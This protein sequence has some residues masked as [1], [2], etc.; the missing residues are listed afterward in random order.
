VSEESSSLPRTTLQRILQEGKALSPDLAVQIITDLAFTLAEYHRKGRK[1]GEIFPDQVIIDLEKGSDILSLTARRDLEDLT[2]QYLCFVPPELLEKETPTF[3]SDIYSLGVILYALL[4]GR[5]PFAAEDREVL[6]QDILNSKFE[7]LPRLGGSWDQLDWIFQKCVLRVA[8]RRFL[9]AGEFAEELLKL[10]EPRQ[11]VAASPIF[12]ARR[13]RRRAA[14]YKNVLLEKWKYVLPGGLLFLLVIVA[15]IFWLQQVPV[16]QDFSSWKVEQLTSEREMELDPTVSPDGSSIAYVSNRA[17]NWELFVQ[18]VGAEDPVRLSASPGVESSPHWSPKGDLIL[19]TYQQPGQLPTIFAVPPTGGIPQKLIADALDAQWG[20]GGESICYTAPASK[21]IRGLYVMNP[22]NWETQTI[23]KAEEGLAHPSFSADGREIVFETDID[24]HHGLAIVKVDSKKKWVLTKDSWDYAPSW[25][26]KT[27]TIYFSSR[28]SGKFQIWRIDREGQMEQLTKETGEDFRPM[29]SYNGSS[30]VF[31]RKNAVR[32]IFALSPQ[33]AVSKNES[34]AAGFS[35]FPRSVEGGRSIAFLEAKG[36]LADLQLYDLKTKSLNTVLK[37]IPQTV[38]FSA[39]ARGDSLFMEFPRE[40]KPGIQQFA[41][42]G[43]ASANLGEQIVLPYE[44]SPD[45]NVLFYG[46]RF[47]DDVL[48]LLKNLRTQKEEA[49]LRLSFA[50]RIRRAFWIE[51]G[52]KVAFLSGYGNLQLLSMKDKT[53]RPVFPD[54]CYDFVP[55][56]GSSLIAALVGGDPRNTELILYDLTS[57]KR[58]VLVSF[59]SDAYA[60]NLDWDRDGK[61]IYFDRLKAGA[62]LYSIVGK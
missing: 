35:Y 13:L 46:K 45:R 12:H 40:V 39:S 20:P 14:D 25:N 2:L 60:V 15:L 48:Y 17:G 29:P 52:R 22:Q 27:G 41:L 59:L 6:I 4:T 33:S 62:D 18:R 61:L 54:K 51:Q 11:A 53:M 49:V 23:L 38:R 47:Q 24:R 58:R 37:S 36:D 19:Y 34:P 55:K 7:P 44:L 56:P 57:K 32:D 1:H 3:Q 9:S 5:V 8:R 42:A 50:G 26:W 10:E 28:R 16:A 21:G 43:G 31:Y 30:V